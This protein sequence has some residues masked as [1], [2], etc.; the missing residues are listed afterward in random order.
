[1][2]SR[3]L[4]FSIFFLFSC[5]EYY[6]FEIENAASSLVVEG[7][8]SDQS[9]NATKLYPSDGR[10]FSIKLRETSRVANI[11]DKAITDAIVS[12]VDS[13]GGVVSYVESPNFPGTYFLNNDNFS[14]K[15]GYQYKLVITITD[16][17]VYETNWQE[18]P[19]VKVAEMGE[20]CFEE[21]EKKVYR[22][23]IDEYVLE[24]E[25]GVDISIDL[26]LNFSDE[27]IYYRW[28]YN[29]TWVYIAPLASVA[30][31]DY[32]CWAT[33][34]LYLSSYTLKMD[35]VG[36]YLNDLVYM[37]LYRNE[38]VFEEFSLLVTQ[39]VISEDEFYFWNEMKVQTQRGGL[40]D[41]PP[42]NLKSNLHH[43]TDSTKKVSGHFGVIKE[44]AV[45]WNF[46]IDDLS[47]KT[48]N[49]LRGDCLVIYGRA[50]DPAPECN[51]CLLYSNGV[52]TNIKPD[53]W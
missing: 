48:D 36:G 12:L 53:W 45:R 25:K 52:A 6:E 27:P 8:I 44:T 15:E 28:K 43:T 5:V 51:S 39:Q 24:L 16:D 37:S 17:E 14:A 7:F 20:V 23:R 40:F 13:E 11:H 42:Y 21:V 4:I 26:P 1:M 22:W 9:Y 38:R 35:E 32:K 18:T 29:P 10:R 46:N 50:P 2:N 30:Q 49:Y 34:E 3:L 33:N 41:A 19:S 31:P 47:Y